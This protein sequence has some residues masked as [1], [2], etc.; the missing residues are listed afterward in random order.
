MINNRFQVVLADEIQENNA[1]GTRR[2]HKSYF[3]RYQAFSVRTLSEVVIRI[4]I[5]LF[6]HRVFSCFLH[7]KSYTSFL[8]EEPVQ[9]QSMEY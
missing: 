5:G 9:L 3:I 2:S 8:F 4:G 7:T 1:R 6:A